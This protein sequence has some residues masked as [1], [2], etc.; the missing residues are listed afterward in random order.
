MVPATRAAASQRPRARGGGRPGAMRECLARYGNLVW[1]IARRFDPSDAEDAV[2]EIFLD[3]W[4]SAGRFDPRSARDHVHRDDR[5][6]PVDRS[7]ADAR[8]PPG[9][10]PGRRGRA[11]GGRGRRRP[12]PLP[13][14]EAVQAAPRSTAAPGAAPSARALDVPGMSH[15]EIA[16][17]TGMPLGTVKAHARRGLISIRAALLGVQE[18]EP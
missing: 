4:K 5:A 16:E 3:L 10:G 6:A 9:D 8:P 17:R 2:Q 15:G 1:S 13:R 11:R 7:P 18:G 14:A 12:R